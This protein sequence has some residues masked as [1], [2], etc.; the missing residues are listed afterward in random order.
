MQTHTQE[1][2]LRVLGCMNTKMEALLYPAIAFLAAFCHYPAL[3]GDFVFDDNEAILTNNDI[4]P[5]LSSW[6]DVFEHDFWG[7]P[8]NSSTSHKSYR[9]LTMLSFRF[10]FLISGG[11]NPFVFHLVNLVLHSF[12]VILFVLVAQTLQKT[13]SVSN[14]YFFP[15]I[16]GALFATH[17]IHTESVSY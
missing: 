11:K 14:G 4:D 15:L 7:N 9:P 17:P 6:T 10:D 1:I 5:N 12:V 8:I 16:A 13:F 3:L 2:L